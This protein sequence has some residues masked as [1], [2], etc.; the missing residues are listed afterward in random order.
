MNKPFGFFIAGA[1]IATGLN[2]AGPPPAFSQAVQLLVVDIQA[3][4]QGYRTSKETGKT[5]INGHKEKIGTIDDFVIDRDRVLFAILQVGGFLGIG[6]RL[7]AV[8]YKSLVLDDPSGDVVLPGASR[9]ALKK[10]PEFQ[11]RT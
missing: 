2:T 4:G 7:V 11:Y 8:P 3:V 6:G 9:D 1:V 5:V 10:L